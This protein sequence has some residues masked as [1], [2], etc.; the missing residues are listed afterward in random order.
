LVE[1][2]RSG[3]LQDPD[4]VKTLNYAPGPLDTDMQT[5]IRAQDDYE[6]QREAFKKMH[7]EG[8]LIDPAASAAKLI[9]LLETRS[10]ESGA[11][12]DYYDL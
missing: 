2:I 4:R 6:P 5:L 10:F 3:A 8:T 7:E 9:A 1:L 11:H 12:I